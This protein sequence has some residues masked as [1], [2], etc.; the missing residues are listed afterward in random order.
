MLTYNDHFNTLKNWRSARGDAWDTPGAYF[1]KPVFYFDDEENGLLSTANMVDNPIKAFGSSMRSFEDIRSKFNQLN[2]SDTAFNYLCL[3]GEWERADMA[4]EF[5]KMLSSISSHTPWYIQEITGLD[6]VLE[7]QYKRYGGA[8]ELKI[9]DESPKIQMK[10]LADAADDRIATLFDIYRTMCFDR[11]QNKEVVPSNLRHFNMGIFIFQQP[12]ANMTYNTTG[13]QSGI[14][15]SSAIISLSAAD[16]TGADY[17][18]SYKYYELRGCEFRIDSFKSGIGSFNQGEMSRH[19]YAIDISVNEIYEQRLNSVIGRMLTDFMVIDMNLER[20]SS[21]S[22]WAER[23]NDKN[24]TRLRSEMYADPSSGTANKVQNSHNAGGMTTGVDNDLPSYTVE[25]TSSTAASQE[26]NPYAKPLIKGLDRI[27][28]KASDAIK[29]YTSL[30]SLSKNGRNLFFDNIIDYIASG[31][32]IVDSNGSALGN[33][34]NG[35][36]AEARNAMVNTE[37]FRA[38]RN[39]IKGNLFEG[40]A[41]K[42]ASKD[43][44]RAMSGDVT[45]LGRSIAKQVNKTAQQDK[46]VLGKSL[47]NSL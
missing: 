17:N 11:M 32:P 5:V 18:A 30:P 40:S 28:K 35:G 46:S 26:L 33:A 36:L 4:V 31:S 22:S 1:F 45:G 10:F 39:T 9:E 14:G 7:D 29:A 43:I 2:Y 44:D 27:S 21:I 25:M 34:I 15:S 6:T 3:N 16:S 41:F 19:E 42:N 8:S 20:A 13:L 12:L 38:L 23:T 37:G 47:Y 24:I